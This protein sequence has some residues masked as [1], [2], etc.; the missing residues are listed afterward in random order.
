MLLGCISMAKNNILVTGSHRSGTTWVGKT[1][2][3]HPSIEYIQEPFNVTY[4]NEEFGYKIDTW[5]FY[6]PYSHQEPDVELAFNRLFHSISNP[7]IQALGKNRTKKF[8]F[9]TSLAFY[10]N[11]FFSTLFPKRTLIKDPIALLS[12]GW[13]YEKFQLK[14][15][16]MIRNPLAFAG[17]LKKW[18]WAFD[19][20]HLKRQEHLI[21]SHLGD[22]K[23]QITNFANQEKSIIDQACLIWNILHYVIIEYRN[24][25]PNWLF[26]RHEDLAT[27]PI[28]GFRMIFEFLELNVT[29][30]VHQNLKEYT[31]NSNPSE[32]NNPGFQPRNSIGSLNTWKERL[33]LSEI[34]KI[35][36]ET[37]EIAKNFYHIDGNTFI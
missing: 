13:L 25:Y 18:N 7:F 12:A 20:S 33:T 35:V 16:C 21:Q 30:S 24:K 9:N 19:F 37:R 11:L 23:R 8:T 3:L 22:F 36:S 6:V 14:V 17:S 29:K 34:E 32:A 27:D 1:I 10:K 5:Y 31:S 4:P 26:I 15:I 2:A 28:S